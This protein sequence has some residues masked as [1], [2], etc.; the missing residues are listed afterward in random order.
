MRFG[1]A[2]PGVECENARNYLYRVE[3]QSFK[4]LPSA[5]FHLKSHFVNAI[6]T[7]CSKTLTQTSI[8]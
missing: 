5:S 3:K 2:S 6:V 4:I 1:I 8:W 7:L